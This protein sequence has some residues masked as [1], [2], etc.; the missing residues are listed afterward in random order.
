VPSFCNTFPHI[1]GSRKN[2]PSLIPCAI[3]QDPYFRMTRDVAAR[4]K[5]EKTSTFYSTF[6]PGLEGMKGKMSSSDLT[7]T[8][9]LTDSPA[10]VKKKIN[11]YAFSGGGATIEEQR[12]KG[13]NLDVDMSYQY[14]KFF[15]EDDAQLA[16]IGEQY[17]TGKMLTGE[18]K[19]I[20]IETLSQFLTE[21]QTRRKAVTD[22][23][24]K[25]FMEV[26]PI[27]PAPKAFQEARKAKEAEEAAKKQAE[28][29]AAGK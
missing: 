8:I 17:R 7:H 20:L 1:F 29:A 19:N 22:E 15:L 6:F 5:Y 2:V 13:A 16:E 21:F 24:V 25:K 10:D 9:L 18:I 27:N 23:M 26:R 3:D 4:L 14:L 12:E 28:A 11:K